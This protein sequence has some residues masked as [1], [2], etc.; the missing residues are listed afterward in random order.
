[1]LY[2]KLIFK[3]N[4]YSG[5][6]VTGYEGSGGALYLEKIY[7]ITEFL[8]ELFIGNSV[9]NSEGGALYATTIT[10]DMNFTNITFENNKA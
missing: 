2:E 7:S 8:N 4:Y 5:N 9:A 10:M 6:S 3:N 1:M